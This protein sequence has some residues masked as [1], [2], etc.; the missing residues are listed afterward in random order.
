M[1]VAHAQDGPM[2]RA[3][4]AFAHLIAGTTLML[5][6]A[7]LSYLD[8]PWLQ[9]DPSRIWPSILLVLCGMLLLKA[10]PSR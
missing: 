9:S 5:A 3:I 1:E 10:A 7:L 6:G 4:I 8:V 2:T